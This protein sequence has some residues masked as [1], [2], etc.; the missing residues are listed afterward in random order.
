LVIALM[1]VFVSP[2]VSWWITRR[3]L[4]SSE[5]IATKQVIAPMRQAW[6]NDLR[7]RLAELLSS[8]SHYFAAGYEN[9]TMEEY[10]RLGQLEQEILLMLN[11]A[12]QVH[13]DLAIAVKNIKSALDTRKTADDSFIEAH[14]RAFQL[15]R[16]ILKSEWNRVKT[17][18]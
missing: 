11:P 6:I 7:T 17:G 1:A 16:E 3:T 9:R 10:Q 14:Q 13:T 15:G 2:L 8:T 4:E 18:T 5:R 12:E